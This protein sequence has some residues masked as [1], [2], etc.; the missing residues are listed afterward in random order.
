MNNKVHSV[1]PSVGI[2][3][4]KE[5]FGEYQAVEGKLSRND[6]RM[7]YVVGPTLKGEIRPLASCWTFEDAV[8]LARKMHNDA[9]YT[10]GK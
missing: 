7:A 6:S 3:A 10:E 9:T 8:A 1:Y 2:Y 5:K 4:R